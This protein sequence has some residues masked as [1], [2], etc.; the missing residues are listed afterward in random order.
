[1]AD[2]SD[3]EMALVDLA[4]LALYPTGS[5]GE[6][7]SPVAG[8]AVL[9]YPGWPDP[10]SLDAAMAAGKAHVSVFPRPAERNTTRYPR[11]REEGA[12]S[13]ATYTLTAAGQVITVGGAAPGS[14]FPQ[15]LVALVGGRPYAAQ[16]LAGQTAAQ[17]A[18]ALATAIQA[19]YPAATILGAAITL[20]ATA[21]IGALRVG[22]GGLVKRELRRQER[23]FQVTTWAPSPATRRA[24]AE[25]ID[26]AITGADFLT[27]ADG[28]RARVIYHGTMESDAVQKQRI[29]RRDL[30]FTVEYPTIATEQA[31]ELVSGAVDLEDAFGNLIKTTYS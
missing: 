8:L 19:D 9:I 28:S 3:V 26:L 22:T 30:L 16:S 29:Y 23:Q 18:Q 2:L 31:T 12:K 10:A 20:P 25:P 27:L 6:T 13:L 11:D 4:G 7:P 14:Y 15:N 24:V 17:V 1:M 21:H 5:T